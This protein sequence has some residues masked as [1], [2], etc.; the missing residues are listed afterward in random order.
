MFSPANGPLA[1][2]QWGNVTRGFAGWE[3]FAGCA[4]SQACEASQVGLFSQRGI[5]GLRMRTS[6]L[7]GCVFSQISPMRISLANWMR[8]NVPSGQIPPSIFAL[9]CPAGVSMRG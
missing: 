1:R 9:D 2:P 8:I 7:T 3:S 5:A 6:R 4:V